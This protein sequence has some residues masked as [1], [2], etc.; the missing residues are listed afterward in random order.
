VTEAIA[1]IILWFDDIR[2]TQSSVT[3]SSSDGLLIS[4]ISLLAICDSGGS[5]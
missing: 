3:T 1:T 5:S 4:V 2:E